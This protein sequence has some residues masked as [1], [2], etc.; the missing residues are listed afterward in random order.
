MDAYAVDHERFTVSSDWQRGR[1]VWQYASLVRS[2]RRIRSNNSSVDL[3]DRRP[4][5]YI[6]HLD[7]NHFRTIGMR[8]SVD[9]GVNSRFVTGERLEALLRV[10][11]PSHFPVS[12]PD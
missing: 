1:D 11:F 2:T 10:S 6:Q 9:E 3:H 8:R 4:G 7:F 12:I 5:R